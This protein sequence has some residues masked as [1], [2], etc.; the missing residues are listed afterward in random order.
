MHQ[1]KLFQFERLAK[2]V[3]A[4]RAVPEDER[5]PAA[6]WWWGSAI[7]L[8]SETGPMPTEFCAAFGAPEGASYADAAARLMDWIAPQ[9]SLAFPN[10]FP[11]KPKRHAA[12]TEDAPPAVA[13]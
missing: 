13:P 10:E 7:E 5:A 1:A 6:A 3:S 12:E 9:K 8:R 4:W 2:E 11:S